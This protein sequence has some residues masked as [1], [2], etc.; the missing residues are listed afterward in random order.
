MSGFDAEPADTLTPTLDLGLSTISHEGAIP[1]VQ[2]VRHVLP[3]DGYLFWLRTKQTTV[4]GSLHIAIDQRQSEDES[5]AVNSVVF[6]TTEEIEALNDINP[7]VIWVGEWAGIKFAFSRRGPYYENAKLYHY[8]GEAV[9]PAMLS[10]LVDVGAQL[11]DDTLIISNSLPAWLTIRSYSPVW[12]VPNNPAVTLY[13]SFLV[14]DNLPPPYGVVHIDP[15]Q[16]NAIQGAPLQGRRATHTQLATDT[17]RITLYGLTNDQAL[18]WFDTVNSF[19]YDTDVIGIMNMPVIRDEKRG[20][21]GMNI[22]AMKKTISFQVSYYQTRINDLA[23][24]MIT[25]ARAT[26]TPTGDA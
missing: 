8:A 25:A 13:P 19:S 16:T 10:Q 22:L 5:P 6:T 26:I 4:S 21:V 9:Y 7:N 18:D 11:P 23:R 20:Q 14:P 2:Y 15:N 3:L 1:F 24:Q 12:L 17:A